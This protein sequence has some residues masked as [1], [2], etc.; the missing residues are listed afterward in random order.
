MILFVNTYIR[1]V[2]LIQATGS[3]I[4]GADEKITA[5]FSV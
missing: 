1:D 2:S 4:D 5:M 3:D